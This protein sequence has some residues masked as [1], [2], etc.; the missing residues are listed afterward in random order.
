MEGM[1]RMK[2]EEKLVTTTKPYSE[3]SVY[4]SNFNNCRKYINIKVK[5]TVHIT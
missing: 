1:R 4:P 3:V 2:R 5:N